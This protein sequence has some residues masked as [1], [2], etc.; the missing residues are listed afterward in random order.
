MKNMIAS[1][2]PQLNKGD[3]IVIAGGGGFI[4]GWLARYYQEQGFTNIRAV[5][6]KP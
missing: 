2:D 4:G 3:L 1:T 5:D 6:K